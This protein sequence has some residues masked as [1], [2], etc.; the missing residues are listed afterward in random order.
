M[1]KQR[2]ETE[3]IGFDYDLIL[4]PRKTIA[5]TVHPDSEVTLKAPEH[6]TQDRLD[7]FLRRKVRW[8]LKQ[9]RY[10]Y[11]FKKATHKNYVSGETFRYLGR[12]Y[13]LL[14]SQTESDERVSLQFGSINVFS[15]FPK[16]RLY[17]KKLLD[18]WY[19]QNAVIKF[20]EELRG[21]LKTY[22]IENPP[23]LRIRQMKSRWGSYSKATHS[24][25]LNKRLIQASRK[26]IDYVITHELCHME[27]MNHGS[28]FYTLLTKRL[29][30]WKQLKAALESELIN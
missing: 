10:F 19:E 23:T 4:Q 6:A 25:S 2:F 5:V 21:C 7:D 14:V 15:H 18:R 1:M 22:G 26:Q 24:I 12:N 8:V 3:N 29:P 27:Y 17:T 9:Q 20:E 13:K 30:S 28:G 11:E 16:N